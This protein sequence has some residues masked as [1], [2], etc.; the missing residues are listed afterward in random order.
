MSRPG[1]GI[2]TACPATP[3]SSLKAADQ[4]QHQPSHPAPA[5]PEALWAQRW[6]YPF[7]P[8]FFSGCDGHLDLC[9]AP[10][11]WAQF[12][13]PSHLAHRAGLGLGQGQVPARGKE[14]T[15][16]QLEGAAGTGA[17]TLP[18]PGGQL[19][20][21]ELG[22]GREAPRGLQEP[23]VS[24]SG[25]SGLQEHG[26]LYQGAR[27]KEGSCMVPLLQKEETGHRNQGGHP[28]S[29]WGAPPTSCPPTPS[30]ASGTQVTVTPLIQGLPY[31]ALIISHGVLPLGEG[32]FTAP[33]LQRG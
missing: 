26:P 9:S 3:S 22:A 29:C 16:F 8:Q 20:P 30:L 19:Q 33:A 12:S 1:R 11:S 27:T 4:R 17:R 15:S 6:P 23:R 7:P 13:S 18:G 32:S 5:S 21:R 24:G 25:L 28:I 10:V 2:G 14:G 31:R